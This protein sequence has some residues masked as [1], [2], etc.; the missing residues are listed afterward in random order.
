MHT[1]N[2]PAQHR[3]FPP[4]ALLWIFFMNYCVIHVLAL[5]ILDKPL[6]K[7]PGKTCILKHFSMP[8]A[9]LL[10]QNC[11]VNTLLHRACLYNNSVNIQTFLPDRFKSP[12]AM[13]TAKVEVYSSHVLLVPGFDKSNRIMSCIL[14]GRGRRRDV[15]G[16]VVRNHGRYW[17][18]VSLQTSRSAS[19]MFKRK[20]I[21]NCTVPACWYIYFLRFKNSH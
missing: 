7:L 8:I 1:Q 13:H 2:L 3:M 6:A 17:R 20:L 19:L 18:Y 5:R 12:T 16:F 21:Q 9:L 11:I 10:L 15:C 4:K 14:P